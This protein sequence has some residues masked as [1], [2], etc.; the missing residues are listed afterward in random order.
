MSHPKSNLEIIE[1]IP[2]MYNSDPELADKIFDINCI[3]HINGTTEEGKGPEVIKNS[4]SLM[5][6]QFTDSRTV[7]TEV[8]SQGDSV[9]VR[10]TWEA[11]DIQT[12]K[13]WKLNGNTIF[14][15]KN[16]KITEYW[17]EDDRLREM[18]KQGFTLSPP[19][20]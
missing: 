10:W 4:L 3:H 15:F 11:V 9:A 18:L 1:M 12:Q 19:Q 13:K 8:I 6:K 16:G 7:F 5:A 2:K 20:K 14:H 17:A